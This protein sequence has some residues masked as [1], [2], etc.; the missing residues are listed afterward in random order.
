[1]AWLRRQKAP[2][3][4][5]QKI[6]IPQIWERCRECGE[7]FYLKDFISNQKV[8]PKCQYHYQIEPWNRLEHLLDTLDHVVEYDKKL[9][10]TDPLKFSDTKSYSRRLDEAQKKLGQNDAFISIKG[11]MKGREVLVGI[12]DFRFMGGSM[13]SVVGEKIS[14][15]FLKSV[16]LRLPVIIFSASGGAR[17]QEGIFSLM[18]MAKTC[19]SL[20]KMKSS[21]LP[22]ISVL[23]HPT[24]GGVAASFAMLGDVN[25]GEPGALIG[26]AGPRVI[27]QTIR[28]ELPVGF[29]SSEFLLEH[30]MLDMIC[31]REN[32]REMLAQILE[33]LTYTPKD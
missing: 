5:S 18:Q 20:T 23:T 16:E 11:L 3:V 7:I 1:M 10:S 4:K 13:G 6:D 15:L 17:M 25:I 9:K 27:R 30:G 12:F 2:L 28:Q 22:F 14:R 19:A 8:C 21:G 31:H 26:F 29:Q 33:L 32:Q 24:T